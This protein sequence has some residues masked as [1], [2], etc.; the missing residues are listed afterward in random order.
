MSS[1]PWRD[2]AASLTRFCE[3]LD[4]AP[5]VG[6]F[7]PGSPAAVECAQEPLADKWGERPARD[8]NLSALLLVQAAV[9]H[10]RA[11]ATVLT[12][13]GIIYAP[14]T[15]ARG[16]VE[17]AAQAF[18]LLDPH[19]DARER[20]RRHMNNL[21]ASLHEVRWLILGFENAADDADAAAAARPSPH[22]V[23][24]EKTDRIQRILESAERHGFIVRRKDDRMRPPY[25]EPQPPKALSL[26]ETAVSA[27]DPQLGATYWR[28]MSSVAHSQPHGLTPFLARVNLPVDPVYGDAVGQ[29]QASAQ[30]T[31]LR[32]FG[33]PLAAASL[34]ERLFPHMGW[35][36]RTMQLPTVTVLR[37]W[38]RVANVPHPRS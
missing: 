38:A 21:L 1:N 31:A 22:E 7:A 17:A 33:T 11:L 26:V 34:V 30:E 18:Y 3:A 32:L 20:V 25:L 13:Q 28:L 29:V 35:D 5:D 9:D 36:L 2:L 8:A 14:A 19:I 16:A 10:L 27:A 12:T 4:D 24:A 6:G 23:A 37:V 15:L